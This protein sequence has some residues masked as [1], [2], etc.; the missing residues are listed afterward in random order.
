VSK[1]GKMRI[2]NRTPLMRQ[3]RF[4]G[5]LNTAPSSYRSDSA[6]SIVSKSKFA[7][8][9]ATPSASY[10]N[11]ASDTGVTLASYSNRQV[12]QITPLEP[13]RGEQSP[14]WGPGAS[15][16]VVSDDEGAAEAAPSRRDD[17][18]GNRPTANRMSAKNS[19]FVVATYADDVSDVWSALPSI[20]PDT[21]NAQRQP[22]DD[23]SSSAEFLNRHAVAGTLDEHDSIWKPLTPYSTSLDYKN[24]TDSAWVVAPSLQH[25]DAF[26]PFRVQPFNTPTVQSHGAAGAHDKLDPYPYL[27]SY[28][29]DQ[30]NGFHAW[31]R[32]A[33]NTK[34]SGNIWKPNESFADTR[35][36]QGAFRS[37]GATSASK[38]ASEM[39]A[40]YSV[41][42]FVWPVN[43]DWY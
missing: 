32:N 33:T 20:M 22:Q 18:A 37:H 35:S 28:L 9:I 13:Y 8:D 7:P 34:D 29:R 15:S 27:F 23:K 10:S 24:S 6:M 39:S 1:D 5:E 26:E 36:P 19:R 4:A 41:R 40:S 3:A 14:M 11:Q 17:Q 43:R 16:A 30:D 2:F 12:E 38:A 25:T 31:G 42:K 21:A